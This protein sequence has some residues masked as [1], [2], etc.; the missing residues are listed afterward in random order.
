MSK[1]IN[2]PEEYSQYMVEM[3]R[4]VEDTFRPDSIVTTIIGRFMDRA[5]KGKQKYGTTLDRTDLT[6]TEWVQHLQD[7]LHDAYLYSEKLKQDTEKK[8]KLLYLALRELEDGLEGEELEEFQ[9]L[10]QWHRNG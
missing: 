6:M 2:G 9:Q 1:H 10:V 4:Q 7:E 8:D 5:R 3:E